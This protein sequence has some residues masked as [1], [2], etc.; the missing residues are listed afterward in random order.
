MEP[1]LNLNGKVFSLP[2]ITATDPQIGTT[3]FE[4]STIEFC[5]QWLRGEK[6]FRLQTSGSTGTP[7]Q[8]SISRMQMEASAKLTI[9]AL[10]LKKGSNSLVCLDTQYIAGKMMLVRSLI[11]EM[12]IFAV[13]PEAN[14]FIKV[15]SKIDFAAFVPYQ[16]EKI[17]KDSKDEF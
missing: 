15:K 10:Q 1:S 9:E 6:E 5:K 13:T 12:N 7:K 3:H 17:L 4:K 11:N 2:E 14:P 16:V 8:I